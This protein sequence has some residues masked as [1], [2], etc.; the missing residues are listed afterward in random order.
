M[1]FIVGGG[2]TPGQAAPVSNSALGRLNVNSNASV[3]MSK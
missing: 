1:N 2:L 3:D